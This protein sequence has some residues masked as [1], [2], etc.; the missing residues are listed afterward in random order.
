[1]KVIQDVLIMDILFTKP[2]GSL[3]SRGAHLYSDIVLVSDFPTHPETQYPIY[4]L[5]LLFQ[6]ITSSG[7]N[8][9]T[10]TVNYNAQTDRVW[11]QFHMHGLWINQAKGS[12]YIKP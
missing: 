7:L 6:C 3:S 11:K 4:L 9:E 12:L 1:M 5:T 10:E 8:G 2:K